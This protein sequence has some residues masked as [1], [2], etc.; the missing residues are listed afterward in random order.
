MSYHDLDPCQLKKLALPHR[1][2]DVRE[3]SEFVLG[4][5]PGAELVPLGTLET[6]ARTWDRTAPIV[7]VCRSGSRSARG[8]H[9]L[10]TMGFEN[11]YNLTGGMLAY[12]GARC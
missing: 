3:P 12:E 2:I 6:A 1:L 7:V 8:A 10:L 5:V 11:V 4:H 9:L